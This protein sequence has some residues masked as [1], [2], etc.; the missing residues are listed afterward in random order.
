MQSKTSASVDV[1]AAM[2]MQIHALLW[3]RMIGIDWF[4]IVKIIPVAIIARYVAPVSNRK[5]G[6]SL[7]LIANLFASVSE[8]LCT[9]DLI[10]SLDYTSNTAC[11]LRSYSL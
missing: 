4:A 2:G 10:S 1:V 9:L 3:T 5:D 6:V 8:P 11:L 7:N